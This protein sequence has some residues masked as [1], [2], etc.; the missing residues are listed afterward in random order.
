VLP[1]GIGGYRQSISIS[2][3]Y[4]LSIL[5]LTGELKLTALYNEYLLIIAVNEF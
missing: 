2:S 4:L 3:C 1:K 5:G